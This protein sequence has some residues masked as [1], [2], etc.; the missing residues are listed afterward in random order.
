MHALY[1]R[2]PVDENVQSRTV[3]NEPFTIVLGGGLT[4][5][6]TGPGHFIPVFPGHKMDGVS[7]KR[8]ASV[9]SATSAD[10]EGHRLHNEDADCINCPT[11]RHS[12]IGVS[13]KRSASVDPPP[14]TRLQLRFEEKKKDR[15]HK[16][17]LHSA[18]IRKSELDALDRKDTP[19]D[20]RREQQQYQCCV[21]SPGRNNLL[22][23][24]LL[25]IALGVNA[26]SP[27]VE[28]AEQMNSKVGR[29][30]SHTTGW[31]KEQKVDPGQHAI[32][33]PGQK[34]HFQK[35][36]ELE[37]IPLLEYEYDIARHWPRHNDVL[38]PSEQ[39]KWS[40]LTL[41]AVYKQAEAQHVL[42]ESE[43][44][45]QGKIEHR[46][47]LQQG[48][49]ASPP[50]PVYPVVYLPQPLDSSYDAPPYEAEPPNELFLPGPIV[51]LN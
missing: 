10:G 27:K 6:P 28:N 1:L 49:P 36:T 35:E 24:G 4:C 45:Q 34:L 18:Q 25:L 29:R 32:P 3:P 11:E 2:V 16:D 14:T 5:S 8:S 42:S 30:K 37:A 17:K 31:A 47:H 51:Y 50:P 44:L 7:R 43:G 12:T 48:T 46:R 40:L 41:R 13:R 15:Y 19:E 38:E 21:M 23:V 39:V 20:D 9:D 33:L 22:L 26:Q